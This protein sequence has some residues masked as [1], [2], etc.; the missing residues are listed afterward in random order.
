[1]FKFIQPLRPNDQMN[2]TGHKTIS[3]NFKTFILLAVLYAIINNNAILVS[4]EYINPINYSE[5]HEI[6]FL[7]ISDFIFSTH[8]IKT[9][10]VKYSGYN[11]IYDKIGA[12]GR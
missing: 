3:I 9:T 4:D 8:T 7:L 11:L 2:M 1:M 12:A 5:R 6:D 10:V